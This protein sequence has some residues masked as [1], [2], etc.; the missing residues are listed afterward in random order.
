MFAIGDLFWE[1]A[2]CKLDIFSIYCLWYDNCVC[3]SVLLDFLIFF[4]VEI[5]CEIQP[6]DV[7]FNPPSSLG[8]SSCIFFS[9]L[10][11]LAYACYKLG[12]IAMLLVFQRFLIC[13][14][15]YVLSFVHRP[16]WVAV[17]A[18]SS[19]C[20]SCYSLSTNITFGL[21][22]TTIWKIY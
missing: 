10:E 21:V 6:C 1:Y 19:P 14:T 2:Y 16:H 7:A 22:P 12:I 4:F 15:L 8:R 18:Q 3:V 17:L 5:L 11:L 13:A 20:V 9:M